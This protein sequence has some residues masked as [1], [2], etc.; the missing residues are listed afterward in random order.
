MGRRKTYTCNTDLSFIPDNLMI[1]F[2]RGYFD[3]DGTVG[4]TVGR[5]RKNNQKFENINLCI[6]SYKKDHLIII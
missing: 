2:I 5:K 3:G 4:K 6:Y 1:H